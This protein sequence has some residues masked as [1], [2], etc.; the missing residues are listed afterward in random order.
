MAQR[1]SRTMPHASSSSS[2]KNSS[3]R[4][5][6]KLRRERRQTRKDFE[7]G[8]KHLHVTVTGLDFRKRVG[9]TYSMSSAVKMC[10]VM[11]NGGRGVPFPFLSKNTLLRLQKENIFLRHAA[12]GVREMYPLFEVAMC[13][14]LTS[15]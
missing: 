2:S 7:E 13:K 6:E 15:R 9:M 12:R 1:H 5:R 8:E 10:H 11:L 3:Q 4:R 14:F